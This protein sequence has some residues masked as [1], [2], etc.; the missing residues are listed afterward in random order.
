MR[1]MPRTVRGTIFWAGT[2]WLAGTTLLWLEL[3]ARPRAAITSPQE[4]VAGFRPDGQTFLTTPNTPWQ[5]FEVHGTADAALRSQI[6]VGH[7]GT[8]LAVLSF[9]GR[10]LAFPTEIATEVGWLV[11]FD[12][13]PAVVVWDVEAG[14][15]RFR[16]DLAEGPI[17][18]A[19]DG[20]LLATG[21]SNLLGTVRVWDLTAASPSSRSLSVS[22]GPL[23]SL[24]FSPDGRHFVAVG[25]QLTSP[26]LL[27]SE[28]V[29]SRAP[30]PPASPLLP[31]GG[32]VWWATDDW[33]EVGHVT[34][35]NPS[36]VDTAAAFA[37]ADRIAVVRNDLPRVAKLND[38]ATGAE[39]LI[40][41]IP[42]GASNLEPTVTGSS[43]VGV[44]YYRDNVAVQVLEWLP[45]WVTD[46]RHVRF[47]KS[48]VLYDAETGAERARL[49]VDPSHAF[50]SPDGRTLVAW[51][52]G[53]LAV[54]DVPPRRFTMM[55]AM[56][57]MSIGVPILAVARWLI[58]S[59][60]RLSADAA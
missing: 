50:L 3:P 53:E 44:L 20:R 33:H 31:N 52:D 12:P 9:D 6:D 45:R 49:P 29:G 17:A 23:G 32:A 19:P 14:C 21:D 13:M 46:R 54:W 7:V 37:A 48:T 55:W 57:S 15:E 22:P 26:L 38:V 36:L 24:G 28:F 59:L 40:V 1:L 25:R 30:R 10:L 43:S 18:F 47:L 4:W 60:S 58:R 41:P 34:N 11:N 27:M 35:A 8:G 39:Q 5:H 42:A 51:N 56:L 16:L 2:I